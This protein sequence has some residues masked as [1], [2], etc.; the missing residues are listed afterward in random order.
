MNASLRLPTKVSLLPCIEYAIRNGPYPEDGANWISI[1]ANWWRQHGAKRDTF[2]LFLKIWFNDS[3]SS[4]DLDDTDLDCFA[5]V[6][7]D[8][9]TEINCNYLSHV[10]SFA[11]G[12]TKENCPHY[13]PAEGAD[14]LTI[15]SLSAED[16]IGRMQTQPVNVGGLSEELVKRLNIKRLPG[17]VLA[18]YNNGVYITEDSEYLIDAVVRN[19]LKNEMNTKLRSNLFMHIRAL[20]DPVVWDDFERFT[21]LLCCPNGVVDLTSGKL[22]EHDP[23]YMMLRKTKV[24][25][26]PKADRKLWEKTLE[27]IVTKIDI[28]GPSKNVFEDQLDYHKKI[29]GLSVT[30]ETRDEVLFI[31]QGA[32][33]SGKTV[34]TGTVQ[35]AMGQ[36]VQQVSP[37][38]FISKSDH[39]TPS[40]EL[41]NGVGVR[42]FLTNESK[43]GGRINWQ[44]IKQIATEGQEFNAR[45][46]RER[47]FTYTLRGKAHLVLNPPPIIDEHDKS[48]KRRLHMI[49]YTEDFTDRADLTLKKTLKTEARGILAWLV[50]G[51]IA[52]YRDGLKPTKAVSQAVA[53]LFDDSDPLYGFVDC[54]L[55]EEVGGRVSARELFKSFKT[56][57]NGMMVNTE[58][59]DPR[60]F[61]RMLNAQLRLKGWKYRKF[62]SNGD[63][64]YEDLAYQSVNEYE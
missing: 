42:I 8:D 28:G 23:V 6:G 56:H 19:Y 18:V 55:K 60:P 37:D 49:R 44:L 41:A 46:I 22:L 53:E 48:I 25:Y 57:C 35:N 13:I 3:D 14:K 36:Y 59:I 51:A 33:G 39:Y 15:P 34:I 63:T 10:P 9:K 30:G 2:P 11:Q 47:P 45:Q 31:H 1:L 29:W 27:E 38:I 50:E 32:G 21:H 61:G 43:D 64:V 16:Y 7:W 62:A 12:C 52:Y 24:P 26:D 40:Y 58:K 54:T 17:G 20:A 5:D 4:E